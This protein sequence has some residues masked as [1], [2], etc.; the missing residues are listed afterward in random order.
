MCVLLGIFLGLVG[1]G[2]QKLL[3]RNGIVRENVLVVVLVTMTGMITKLFLFPNVDW[4][5]TSLVILLANSLGVN[6]PD[7]W[8]TLNRGRWWW[9]RT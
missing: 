5:A 7:L 1:V 3:V 8:T 2:F 9:E 6:G 4:L